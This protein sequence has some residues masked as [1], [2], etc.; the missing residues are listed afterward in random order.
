[1]GPL[2]H[3]FYRALGSAPGTFRPSLLPVHAAVKPNA[4]SGTDIPNVGTVMAVRLLRVRL[5]AFADSAESTLSVT[6]RRLCS[7]SFD[8]SVATK[9]GTLH[10][11]AAGHTNDSVDLIQLCQVIM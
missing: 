11:A 3:D 4:P 1:V 6:L 10:T 5:L 8:A 9:N 2:A 7:L